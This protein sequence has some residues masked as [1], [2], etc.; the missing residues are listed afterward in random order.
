M[1]Q[2]PFGSSR[3]NQQQQQNMMNFLR[4]PSN[5]LPQAS[6]IRNPYQQQQQQLN[7]EVDVTLF[8]FFNLMYQF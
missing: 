7:N 3:F 5:Q 4:S 6:G 1:A 2:S 8:A